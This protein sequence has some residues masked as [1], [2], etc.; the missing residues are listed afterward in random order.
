[1]KQQATIFIA[2]LVIIS[3]VIAI[4]VMRKDLCEIRF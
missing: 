2:T 3:T 4:L 1:M